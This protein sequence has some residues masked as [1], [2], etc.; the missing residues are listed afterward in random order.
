M[1][2]RLSSAA[3]AA[4]L[5]VLAGAGTRALTPD[6]GLIVVIALRDQP[7]AALAGAVPLEVLAGRHEPHEADRARARRDA[8][9]LAALDALTRPARA[10]VARHVGELGGR[11]LYSS[12]SVNALAAFIPHAA[13][14]R[15][16]RHPDVAAVE[17]DEPRRALLDIATESMLVSAFWSAG[18]T[19]GAVDAAVVDTGIFTGHGAFAPRTASIAGGVFHATAMQQLN[20][21]DDPASTDDFAGHGTY[22]AGMIFSQ[23]DAANPLRRGVAFGLDRLYNIK[24][25]YRTYPSGG[26]SFLTDLMA[27]VDWALQ[28]PDPPEVFNYSFGARASADDDAFTRFWDGVVDTFGKVATISAGN[29]GPGTVGSPGI[30]HNVISVANV[31]TLGTPARGDDVVADSSSGGPTPGGRKKP[32]LAAPGTAIWLPSH[33]FPTW[34]SPVSGTSFSAPAVAGAAALLVDAGVTDPRAVKAVLINTADPATPGGGWDPRLG[35]GY[36]NGQRAWAERSQV[37]LV[38]LT[39]P[40]TPGAVRFFER[41][42]AAATRATAV[43]HRHVN[44]S[45]GGSPA[46]AGLANI[47]LALYATASGALRALSASSADNVEQVSSLL[48]EP[49]V[50]VIRAAGPI[51]GAETAAFAHSGGFVQRTG[52]R[53]AATMA[54]PGSVEPGATF[55]VSAVVSNPGDLTGHEYVVSLALPAGF[56]IVS[57]NPVRPLGSLAPAGRSSVDWVVRAP[58]APAPP[59]TFAVSAAASAYGEAWQASTSAA[60]TVVAG[61]QY[62]VS[63]AEIDVDAAGGRT[64]VAVTTPAGCTWSALSESGWIT[65][66]DGAPR[67]GSGTIAIDVSPNASAQAR[68]AAVHVAGRIVPVRQAGLA[69]PARR[70]YLAEG[71][72]ASIFTM[73]VAIANPNDTAVDLTVRY[74]RPGAAPIETGLT[75]P[76]LGRRTLRV[77]DV[78]GLE[79]GDV[80]VVVES[81][82]GLPVAVERMMTWDASSYGGHGGAA[83]EAPSVRWYFAEGSQGFFDTYLLLVN[84]GPNQAQVS[85]TYLREHENAVTRSYVVNAESRRT[86]FAG[87]DPELVGRSFGMVVE[88]T[89][90]IVA[91]RAMYWSG[92]GTWWTGGH[93]AS[94]VTAPA[95]SWFLAEGATGAFFE[96]YILVG[97]PNPAPA[98]VTFRWLLPSGEVVEKTVL[99]GAQRRRTV[100]VELEHPR[101]ADTAVSTMVTADVP[102]V[103]ERAMYWPGT[104]SQWADAHAS[105]GLVE[106]AARWA[107]AEGRVGLAAGFETYLLLANPGTSPA[108]VRVTALRENGSPVARTFTVGATSRRN[109]V[110]SPVAAANDMPGLADERFGLLVESLDGVPIVAER[111]MYW[112]SRG[113]AWAAGTGATGTKLP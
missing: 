75:L 89:E 34:W 15:L 26:A 80:A 31:N 86:I 103:V 12:R 43:W 112:T 24:A 71:S 10:R 22:V 35:W 78:P 63:P 90:P 68:A 60:V 30:A 1:L 54:V 20:Y 99:V 4:A 41:S 67:S 77:D 13:L 44:Y 7:G 3:A 6:T 104:P 42:T 55:I 9:L 84:P 32:D 23:G 8:R 16:R 66:E 58:A 25:G 19:G 39:S 33:I 18:V 48:A 96:T 2:R 21:W 109:V 28:Q 87:S 102:I 29:S 57:G 50:V 61:C 37:E 27:G 51:D 56:T 64:T 88:A 47:D 49:A 108:R 82:G 76:A 40:G 59:Q 74:L 46:V 98:S 95:T 70:Y 14:D 93:A 62:S 17:I 85:V 53:V 94:G 107:L 83:V 92:G 5:M 79:A 100:D 106:T 38:S 110:I 52:P 113:V 105:A 101:L 81:P 11:I 69:G 72:T 65:V 45:V 111:A 97:N 91:E 36:V 73:D